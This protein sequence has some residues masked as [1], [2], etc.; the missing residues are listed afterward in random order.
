[1]R[2]AL[3]CTFVPST[4]ITP[5]FASPLRAHSVSTSPNRPAIAS[6]WRSR[7]PRQRRVIRAPPGR[8][9]PQGDVVFARALDHPRGPNPAR[10]GVEQQ[11]DH[12]R[13][14][15]RRPA[16]PID[17]IRGVKRVEVH[18]A[19]GVD[20]EPREL[21]RR[22]PRANI[23]H[24]Q[25]RPL[26]ITRDKALAHHGMVLNPPDDTPTYATA[27]RESDS[28]SGGL[29][30]LRS[31]PTRC[32]GPNTGCCSTGGAHGTVCARAISERR[33]TPLVVC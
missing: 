14:V 10:V 15:I 30:Y 17:A 20:D 33:L 16:A 31:A 3:A 6:S 4:A 7:K 12:H 1:M 24:H 21:P 32:R 28:A 9:H 26:A 11:R 22:Q 5:T 27:T 25:K 8:Q 13:R 23:G 2:D 18:L 19:D 29:V